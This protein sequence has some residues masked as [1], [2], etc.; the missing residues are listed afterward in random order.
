MFRAVT[1]L[2]AGGP[3]QPG[4]GWRRHGRF[5]APGRL[6]F[7]MAIAALAVCLLPASVAQAQS[8]TP[9]FSAVAITS[10]PGTDDTHATGD[11]ITV[12]VTFSEA[13]TVA[14]TPRIT[15]DIGGQPRYAG[16][17]GDG[18]SAAAQ[19]F[20]YTVLVSDQDADGVSVL[21]NSLALDGGTIRATDDSAAA[22]LTHSAMSF[23]D[24]KVDT[25]V[26]LLSNLNQTESS[27][28]I[29]ISASESATIIMVGANAVKGATINSI[30]LDVAT[31]SD[32]L[33]VTVV[34]V[35]HQ[36]TVPDAGLED[37]TYYKYTGS[38][39]SAGLQTF[40]LNT[41][42]VA[43]HG[44]VTSPYDPNF[45]NSSLLFQ[46][47]VQGSGSGSIE[48]K[49]TRISGTDSDSATGWSLR[50]DSSSAGFHVPKVQ[51]LGYD[52]KI[53]QLFYG[54]V[55][56]SPINGTAYAAGE[57]IEFLYLFPT[58]AAFPA[59][60]VVQFWLGNG[61]EHR[62]EAPFVRP[63]ETE[64]QEGRHLMSGF[65]AAYTVQPGD[66][67][68][69]GVYIGAQPIGDNASAEVESAYVGLDDPQIYSDVPADL[70]WPARQLGTSQAVD[71]S[72]AYECHE[73]HC[74]KMV[75][76]NVDR[77]DPGDYLRGYGLHLHSGVFNPAVYGSSSS[78]T[79][80]YVG[81]VWTLWQ[82]QYE[83]TSSVSWLSAVVSFDIFGTSLP[84]AAADRLVLSLDGILYP[85]S[86]TDV[87][88]GNVSF[89]YRNPVI[90]W[91]E[92]DEVEIRLIE[93]ATASFGEATHMK[94]EGDTFD[95]TVNLDEAFEVTTVTVPVTVTPNGGATEAD[96]SG[97]PENLVFAPSEASKTFT[98]TVFDDTEDDDG[99]SITLSFGEENHIRAGVDN[100]TATITLTDND[101]PAVTVEFGQD[102]QGVGEGES[103]NV[104]IGLSADP[105]R[106]VTIPIVATPQ[107]TAS[108]ADYSVPASVTFNDGDTEKTIAFMATDDDDDD[109]DE[110][111]KLGF[112]SSLPD[113]VSEGTRTETTLN[114]G[115]DD[116]PTVTVTF[117]QTAYTVD[118]GATQQV[119]VTVSADP[120]R[121]IIIPITTT[122]QGTA[123]TADY[124]GVPPSVTFTDGTSQTFTFSAT[125]D[126]EDDD[127]E[128]VLLSFGSVLPDR[129]SEGSPNEATVNIADDDDPHVTVMFA[130]ADYV[131]VEGETVLVRVALSADPER[132]VVIPLTATNQGGASSVDYSGVP[133]SVTLSA[134]ET[135]RTFEFTASEDSFA[136]T[137]ESVKLGFGAMPDTRV[138]EGSPN[139][140][141]VNIRQFSTEFTLDCS[142]AVWCADLQFSDQSQLDWGRARLEH[143]DNRDPASALSDDSFSFRG[144]EYEVRGFRLR[145]G[146]YP[147]LANAWSREEQNRSKFVILITPAGQSS[148]P[149][150]AHY[151]DWVL[152]VDG[153]ELPF[154]DVV[155]SQYGFFDWIDA[156]IQQIF[157]DWTPTTVNKVG[158]QE[159]A[160]VDQPPSLAV[161]WLPMAV[162]AHGAGANELRVTWIPPLWHHRI[163]APTG[164]IVQWKLASASWSTPA[165]VSQREVAGRHGRQVAIE[166]LP[167]NTLYSV[168][169][170]PFNDAGDGPV[171]EDALG[172]TQRHSPGLLGMSVNGANLTLRYSRDL[173]P[174]SAPEATSFVV[175][176]NAG[177]LE[178]TAVQ[179]SGRDVNLTLARPVNVFNYVQA[180]YEEPNDPS[181]T[182]LQDTD[183]NRVESK[184]RLDG[185]E[186]AA[187]ETPG[188]SV[189]PLTASFTNLPSSHDG[190]ALFTF[191]V[192]FSEPV[193]ISRGLPRDD[194][195][196]VVGGTVTSALPVERST[197]LWEVTVLPET[198][199]DIIVTLPGG[200]CT[201]VY[202][203]ATSDSLVPGAPCAVGDRALSNPPTVTIPGSESD[204]QIV[205][206]TPA[207]GVPGIDGVAEVGQTLSA[208]TTNITDTD[209]LANVVFTYQWLAD[210]V[211][212]AGATASSHTLTDDDLGKAIRVRVTFTDDAG[213]DESLT[214]VPTAAVT[215]AEALE[216][217]AAT[218]D[219][220]TLTLTYNE[221]LDTGVT[222]PASVFAVEV[223]GTPP[224]ITGVGVVQSSVLLSLS[225]AVEA[226]DTVTV[227]YTRPAGTDVIKDTLGREAE[228]F[229]GEVVTNNTADEE[230]VFRSEEPPPQKSKETAPVEPE[231]PEPPQNLTLE[232]H[233]SG[234]LRATWNTPS[235][236]PAPTGYTVQW[237]EAG[238]DWADSSEVSEAEVNMTSHVIRGLTD[239]A[240]YTVRVIA[241]RDAAGSAPS[242]EV[243]ATPRETTPPGLSSASVDGSTLT[244]TFDEPLDTGEVPDRTAFAVTVAGSGRGVD[245]VAVSGS[246][247]TIT[248]VT[249]VVSRDTVTLAYTAPTDDVTARLQ[250]LVGNAA[251]SFSSQ[252][253]TNNTQ[254]ADPLTASVHGVPAAH[255]GS[256]TFPF[257]LRFSE[258]PRKGFSYNTLRDHAFTVT[259]GDVTK[260]RRLAKGKNV[261][262][263]IH[264]T[265]D[266]DGAVTVALPVTTD[267][268]AEGAICTQDHR[269]LSSRLELT[270]SGP[271]E[272]R[273]PPPNSQATGKPEITGTAREGE[274]LTASRT[275]ISDVDGLDNA[276]F[277]YQWVADG[278][279]IPGATGSTYTLV[280]ADVGKAIRVRAGFTD[281]AGND[282]TLTS[283]ATDAVAAKPNNPATGAPDIN[284]I[285][286]VGETL[287]ASTTGVA[288]EDGLDNVTFSYQWIANDGSAD[289]D[290]SGATDSTYTL[291]FADVDKTIK[292]RMSFTDDAGHEETLT[293][294]ATGA[295]M[296]RPPLTAGFEGAPSS[297][298][299][300]NAFTFRLR[301]SEE[302]PLSYKT[303]RDHAFSV[304]GGQVAKARRLEKGKNVRWEISVT[305]SGDGPVTIVLP[306]T[307]DCTAEGAICTQD[308][309]PLSNRLE[310][311]VPRPGG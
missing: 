218:V 14:G 203:D 124:E 20:S 99:E 27:D 196:E 78:S 201:V 175:L 165:A 85:L 92:N 256:T 122:L 24:H 205:Q 121:T 176:A 184:P 30:T 300:Q 80:S 305:P 268:A 163:P 299:G 93:T 82:V 132:T 54:D 229:S 207:G 2:L 70:L 42:A 206:N 171:S 43:R 127:E 66:T 142:A 281:D 104:T 242:G 5:G 304:T 240:E 172:R 71:G 38:V 141:T 297:H 307:T 77:N 258:T 232:I 302:F 139:E 251:A 153:L 179:V 272:A 183:G 98:V 224:S 149:S 41:P 195:L 189:Q 213:H 8:T 291:T 237:K 107:G 29:T 152:H 262:W 36:E 219:G 131:V 168:R 74:S 187:N 301:F 252:S 135:S 273:E 15:L 138:S 264:V 86:Y 236:G 119:T 214:S 170:F 23:A 185:V 12:N 125:D 155:N 275:G 220:S 250:D 174:N 182:A 101:D 46:L 285:V 18:S 63:L 169:V 47:I 261:R 202:D 102:S 166:G 282:E 156:D 33:D 10:D 188:S 69:D 269:P 235:S 48:L 277:S 103:V 294:A 144:V 162:E 296:P 90:T 89:W 290:I 310:I 32:T 148:A 173:D 88:L 306:V 130:Q 303:L 134:G 81:D 154:K 200:S 215:A 126:T 21:A 143:G 136:D 106:A 158:I 270:V 35:D 25:E 84:Q 51:L 147:T 62:R 17:S 253:V 267:C 194:M 109:D 298:D 211:E 284:G 28:T 245:T 191:N 73:V 59:E 244:L 61:A 246:A 226:G 100:Q 137:G 112:G 221:A 266:G 67:D 72:G 222:P 241:T 44:A 311:T 181:A 140:A 287:T 286:R 13:V 39:G 280:S 249:A 257:E 34:L 197:E 159:V 123:S 117:G 108:A 60:P 52:A 238:G 161:P 212:I 57:R 239:G 95:V 254:A 75:V 53:P 160:A 40:T 1:W 146:T 110:S 83:H 167:G 45:E 193:W 68:T 260:A 255:D 274:T 22:A 309:R 16:Y 288:D 248:L 113:R 243:T 271:G 49:A 128:S 118:E 116:D 19:A 151:R 210:D 87:D 289:A 50:R 58:S 97:I 64:I 198:R 56:S 233:G 96:Y 247:V 308:R 114:I 216:L 129:V 177:I 79:F 9:T 55:I 105:E 3:L 26:L 133:S 157:N 115:D 186:E 295:V 7:L 150:R 208:D 192:E 4:L 227:D 276:A 199:G 190:A 65:V 178:V 209:G 76:G 228:S 231:A 180:S 120:E 265:P 111:V 6:H 259:S 278:S 279:D 11:T 225:P 230:N 293:S 223:N 94:T 164:Y 217:Q 283:A 263:E 204:Q 145:A 37:D 292:V 91:A 31:P 234:K